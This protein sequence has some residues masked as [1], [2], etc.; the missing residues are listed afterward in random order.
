M[1]FLPARSFLSGTAA[2]GSAGDPPRNSSLC[3]FLNSTYPD[4]NTISLP[5]TTSSQFIR[6]QSDS[7]VRMHEWD[8]VEETW[9]AVVEEVTKPKFGDCGFLT[10]CEEYEVCTGRKCTCPLQ[11][12]N[13]S[14]YFKPIG[15]PKDNLGCTPVTPISCQE[16]Q[17][18]Q[19]LT[20]DGVSYFE[21]NH[22]FVNATNQDDCKQVCLKN[23]SC[24]AANFRRYFEQSE[25]D[26]HCLWVTKVYSLQLIKLEPINYK[27]TV[28]I[29]VQLG[30]S[31][32]VPPS[33]HSTNNSNLILGTTIPAI[34]TV[35]LLV[36]ALTIYLQRRAYYDKKDEDFNFDQFA[37][38]TARCSVGCPVLLKVLPPDGGA[39]Q[40]RRHSFI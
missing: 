31:Y 16:M 36:V 29:V 10:V 15:D 17:D 5:T 23:C 28:S 19:F 18:H 1:A 20:L 6:L 25:T 13:S 3:I 35:V 33:V 37:R 38:M 32:S 4:P 12:N 2:A 9:P 34:I 30:P 21:V 26:D 40:Q 14:G 22:S 27:S 24:R 39:R 11:D 8:M 7:H